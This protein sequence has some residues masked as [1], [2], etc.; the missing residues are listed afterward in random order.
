YMIDLHTAAGHVEVWPPAMV[1]R[2]S[3]RGT[4][5]LPKFEDDLF[6]IAGK[7]ADDVDKDGRPIEATGDG[8]AEAADTEHDLFL[9]PTAEVQVTNL[10]AD[11]I[12]EAG[13]LPLRYCAY[14]PCF[15]ADA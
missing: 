11:E 13:T 1:R 10:H 12:L 8:K 9:S 2:T 15:P 14:A 6:R 5:Q 4:G 3:L 7:A